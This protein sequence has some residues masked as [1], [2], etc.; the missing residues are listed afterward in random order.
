MWHKYKDIMHLDPYMLN[1]TTHHFE[2]ALPSIPLAVLLLS[3]INSPFDALVCSI[4][5]HTLFFGDTGCHVTAIFADLVTPEFCQY[6]Q[7]PTYESRISDLAIISVDAE[8]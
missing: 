6:V 2:R 8:L 5:E 3:R 1:I 7:G 4:P